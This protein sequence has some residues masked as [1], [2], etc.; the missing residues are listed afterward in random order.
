M[1]IY[2]KLFFES[3][4]YFTIPEG[5]Y[6]K[7]QSHI[8]TIVLNDVSENQMSAWIPVEIF[9]AKLFIAPIF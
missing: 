2:I 5:Q 1:V 6:T 3:T 9:F 7:K 8:A 4:Y